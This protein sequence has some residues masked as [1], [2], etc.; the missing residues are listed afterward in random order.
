MLFFLRYCA[1]FILKI[2]CT[3]INYRFENDI[4]NARYPLSDTEEEQEKKHGG[5]GMI[6]GGD[7]FWKLC[8]DNVFV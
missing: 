1:R 3:S 5:W 8:S 7:V 4:F 6:V 2:N